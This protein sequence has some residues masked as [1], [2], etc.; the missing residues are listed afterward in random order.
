M[1]LQ[2]KGIKIRTKAR[3]C[4]VRRE[5]TLFSVYITILRCSSTVECFVIFYLLILSLIDISEP[6]RP[7]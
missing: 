3:I 5:Q 1:E 2:Y 7:D 4:G 6:T